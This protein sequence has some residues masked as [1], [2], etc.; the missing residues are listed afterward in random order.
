[1]NLQR[2]TLESHRLP[3]FDDVHKHSIHWGLGVDS[4]AI[5][6]VLAITEQIPECIVFSDP[7]H[8]WPESYEWRDWFTGWLQWY[9]M[10]TPITIR[11]SEVIKVRRKETL[12][13][14]C[15]RLGNDG[16]AGLPSMAFGRH[17]CSLKFKAEVL[18]GWYRQQQWVADEVAEG[19]R[20]AKIIG[21][22]AE[23]GRRARST[24]ADVKESAMSI[25]SYPLMEWGMT[26][27]MC[28]E[29]LQD[30]V[31]RV[32]KKSACVF[33]PHNT[34]D[35]WRLLMTHHPRLFEYCL[36][37]EQISITAVKKPEDVGLR[38]RGKRG[39]RSVVLWAEREPGYTLPDSIHQIRALQKDGADFN[40][41]VDEDR[42]ITVREVAAWTGTP[43]TVRS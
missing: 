22:E 34:D 6:A 37:M 25:P 12:G 2:F 33:C 40:V 28:E 27:Q 4:S 20:I 26:R 13:D 3:Q 32:P 14:E 21:Y 35:E 18:Q 38:R 16:S 23:E 9:G 10:P 5:L 36:V 30:I 11:R 8:E 29:A 43:E 42:H 1:M 7:G 15:I 31:G 24:F 39:D 17:R 19:R 41:L